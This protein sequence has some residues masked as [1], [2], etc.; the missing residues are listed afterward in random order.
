MIFD[1]DLSSYERRKDEHRI[2]IFVEPLLVANRIVIIIVSAAMIKMRNPFSFFKH[3]NVFNSLYF[4]RDSQGGNS[5]V[6]TSWSL[7]FE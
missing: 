7:V 3:G 4:C 1:R 5:E 6:L 2:E